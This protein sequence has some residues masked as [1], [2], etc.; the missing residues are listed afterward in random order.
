MRWQAPAHGSGPNDTDLRTALQ[1]VPILPAPASVEDL[2]ARLNDETIADGSSDLADIILDARYPDVPELPASSEKPTGSSKDFFEP[3]SRTANS[4]VPRPAPSLGSRLLGPTC[5]LAIFAAA[6]LIA[7]NALT[8][9]EPEPLPS[10]APTAHPSEIEYVGIVSFEG[11]EEPADSAEEALDP[12]EPASETHQDPATVLPNMAEGRRERPQPSSGTTESDEGLE[13]EGREALTA[14]LHSPERD[15][16]SAEPDTATSSVAPL[17]R[18]LG[19]GSTEETLDGAA[20]AKPDNRPRGP[21]GSWAASSKACTSR[22]Q[23]RGHIIAYIYPRGARAGDTS[24][25]FEK[26][27]HRPRELY[28]AAS[29]ADGKTT[30]KSNVRLSMAGERLIWTSEKGSTTYVR[31]PRP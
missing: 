21:Y 29:C 6:A 3:I 27:E 26:T 11:P 17:R 31:C 22:M 2:L 4:N 10:P 12:V 23:R 28:V 7:W 1:H 5:G 19:S 9:P 8:P 15:T 14:S 24:C 30:W 25:T 20:E 13:T 16:R 18:E